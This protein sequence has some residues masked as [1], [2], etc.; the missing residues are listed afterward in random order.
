MGGAIFTRP[1]PRLALGTPGLQCPPDTPPKTLTPIDSPKP[2]ARAIPTIPNPAPT[3]GVLLRI[4][5]IPAKHRKNV[6]KNSAS[7]VLTSD[8][9][10]LRG[11]CSITITKLRFVIRRPPGGRQRDNLR[12]MAVPPGERGLPHRSPAGP[13]MRMKFRRLPLLLVLGAVLFLGL[14]STA[15]F[16]TDWLWFKEV[17]FE[18]VFLRTIN[19]Q[20][21]V[22]GIAFVISFLFLFFN[23]RLA[24]RALTLPEVVFGGGPNGRPVVVQTRTVSRLTLPIALI[25]ALVIGYV[26]SSDWLTWM[27]YFKALPFGV[28]DPLFGRD[29]SFYVFRLPIYDTVRQQGLLL[30]FLALV[31]AAML[32]LVSGK[33]VLEPR[34]GVAFWP[35]LRLVPIARRHVALLVALIFA[36]MAWGAWLDIPRM[37]ITQASAVYGASYSNVYAD[38][39]FLRLTIG[40]LVLGCVLALWHGFGRG[41][42]LLPVAIGLYLVVSVVGGVYSGFVQTFVVK[43][44]EQDKE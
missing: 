41:R 3:A 14:P 24:R 36:L 30:C 2:W 31:G 10:T 22:F 44:N 19:A 39:P 21:A 13:A 40:V 42:F 15:V 6:P 8:I 35:R 9:S 1:G 7:A 29:V 43:P 23:W 33:V 37:L 12:F 26:A 5:A 11:Q 4:A 18:S 16:Y 32:Y 20:L 38:L 34:Y 27:T 28:V 25:F 17:G